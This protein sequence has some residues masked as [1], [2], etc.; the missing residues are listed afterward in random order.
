[1]GHRLFGHSPLSQNRGIDEAVCLQTVEALAPPVRL[2]DQQ[3]SSGLSLSNSVLSQFR[4]VPIS[5]SP[6]IP[7]RLRPFDSAHC[8]CVIVPYRHYI[9]L[10]YFLSHFSISLPSYFFFRSGRLGF[11][12]RQWAR[13]GSST[14]NYSAFGTESLLCFS[15]TFEAWGVDGKRA[16]VLSNIEFTSIFQSGASSQ[17]PPPT[18]SC[19]STASRTSTLWNGTVNTV[20]EMSAPHNM[21]SSIYMP[22]THHG[23]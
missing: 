18:K 23:A 13:R 2:S 19:Y 3:Q 4:F 22:M 6:H 14:P 15:R 12:V 1:M 8:M 5:G 16:G 9:F 7:L 11:Q 20:G 21:L 10:W 17:I